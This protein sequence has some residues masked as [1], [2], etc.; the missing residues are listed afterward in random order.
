MYRFLLLLLAVSTV[1]PVATGHASSLRE[2]LAGHFR[3]S[4]IEATNPSV[5]GRVLR[6]G[7]ELRLDGDGVTARA[8]RYV[9][10]NT[11]SPRFHVR[12]Y[13]QVEVG[14]DGRLVTGRGDLSLARGT[15]LVVLGLESGPD[16]VRLLTHTLDPVRSSDGK[17]AYGCTEFIFRFDPATLARADAAAVARRIEQWL[18]V[19]PAS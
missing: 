10:A 11:K 12:D 14:P 9:Q 3:F 13:A 8:M 18:S 4:R 19:T 1:T 2:S 5:E 15:R 17:S 16:R 6:K 7:T